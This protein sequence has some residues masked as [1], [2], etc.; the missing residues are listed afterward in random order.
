MSSLY[1]LTNDY[2]EVL[3]MLDDPDIDEQA[4]IDTCDAIEGAI[5]DKADSYAFI[6]TGIN[7]DVDAIKT[8]QA[9]LSARRRALENRVTLLKRILEDAMRVTGRT[10][11]KT[12]LHSFGIQKN[13]G[14]API[15]I[16]GKVPDEYIRI[17]KEP[18]TELIRE[19]L[20]SGE[21]LDFAILQER[22]E[23]LRI[24]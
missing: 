2:D 7:A 16:Y 6:I 24:R 10:K 23:S 1:K 14:K 17:I 19:V 9:R 8:E 5:E 3:H 11:F 12:A 13:G 18:N 15:D 21:S 4:I 22:G 20:E